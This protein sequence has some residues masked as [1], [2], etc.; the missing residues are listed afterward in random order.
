[1]SNPRQFGRIADNAGNGTPVVRS[2]RIK[3]L[4]AQKLVLET[5]TTTAPDAV[6]APNLPEDSAVIPPVSE[7]KSDTRKRSHD[8]LPSDGESV[9]DSGE[10]NN[11]SADAQRPQKKKAADRRNRRDSRY[12]KPNEIRSMATEERIESSPQPDQVGEVAGLAESRV[13]VDEAR[14][15][16][17]S[18]PDQVEEEDDIQGPTETES[19]TKDKPVNS[20]RSLPEA[21]Q[22]FYHAIIAAILLLRVLDQQ[23]AAQKECSSEIS[24]LHRL[25]NLKKPSM[26][27]APIDDEYQDSR[28]KL[29]SDFERYERNL[30]TRSA[31]AETASRD[32]PHLVESSK[33]RMDRFDDFLRSSSTLPDVACLRDS[34]EFQAIFERCRFDC[35]NLSDIEDEISDEEH[36]IDLAHDRI[37]A[38]A[39]RLAAC[40]LEV[41]G[42]TAAREPTIL[43]AESRDSGY[44]PAQEFQENISTRL[45]RRQELKAGLQK[46]E[47]IH[48]EHKEDLAKM[49]EKLLIEAGM[50][51]P[52]APHVQNPAPAP[53]AGKLP[54]VAGADGGNHVEN[55]EGLPKEE[56]EGK[57]FGNGQ[58][59][60]NALIAEL[61]PAQHH[62]CD[63]EKAFQNSRKFTEEELAKL[64]NK[65]TEDESGRK[66]AR[67]L[68]RTTWNYIDAQKRV[69]DAQAEGRRLRVPAVDRYPIGQT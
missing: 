21:G 46:T 31:Q 59:Q 27:S 55:A 9:A 69:V 32:I 64:P 11:E 43:T 58:A 51:E 6:E 42:W 14:G 45:A 44:S 25:M 15:E 10:N 48:F 22:G 17:K 41:A 60:H 7:P 20:E 67:K 8:P 12:G 52:G 18:Q 33:A 30:E 29:R 57:V 61:M 40:G 63:A 34:T 4:V 56:E 39:S 53:N 1:M 54:D 68:T 16:P 65:I 36:E 3:A 38:Y 2:A 23:R 24:I 26:V 62:L 49:A 35:R 66:L 28:E 47:Q 37:D 19:L 13:M 50:L 5:T